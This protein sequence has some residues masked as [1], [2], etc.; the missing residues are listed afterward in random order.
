MSLNIAFFSSPFHAVSR[1][2]FTFYTYARDDSFAR[3]KNIET[4]FTTV[5]DFVRNFDAGFTLVPRV[6]S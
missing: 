4:H 5:D 2:R 6:D 3:R 1:K